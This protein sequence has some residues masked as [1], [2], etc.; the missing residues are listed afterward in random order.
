[1]G[2]RGALDASGRT[3]CIRFDFGTV[4][5]CVPCGAAAAIM[6]RDAINTRL[7]SMLANRL[8]SYALKSESSF[9]VELLSIAQEA[10]EAVQCNT[11]SFSL[12]GRSSYR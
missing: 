9:M 3:R 7:R 10:K 4:A 1:M 6:P 12:S 5:L 8:R 11:I 2:A